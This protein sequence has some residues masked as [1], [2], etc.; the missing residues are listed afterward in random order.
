MSL[1]ARWISSPLPY[2]LGLALQ[3]M[4]SSVSTACLQHDHGAV[5]KIVGTFIQPFHGGLLMMA[6]QVR[7]PERHHNMF[8][9]HQLFHRRQINPSHD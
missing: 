4:K 8:M 5:V 3:A 1:A 2:Q 7:I 9:P 6:G